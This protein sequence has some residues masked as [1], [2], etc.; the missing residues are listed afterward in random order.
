[1]ITLGILAHVDAGKT[2]LSEQILYNCKAIKSAGRV[3]NGDTLLDSDALEKQR[4]IT[5]YA[6][7]ACFSV[8]DSENRKKHFT[9]LDT[10][11][12]AD[13]SAEMERTLSVL[14]Y[15][16][17]VVSGPEGVQGHTHTLWKLFER[18][19]IPVFIFVNKM[20]RC[21]KSEDDII[22]DLHKLG[23]N[24][25]RPDD[26][27]NIAMCSDEL[28]E[29]YLASDLISE[30]SLKAAIANRKFTPVYFGSALKNE[31]VDEFTKAFAKLTIEKSNSDSDFSARVFKITHDEKH[32]R[33]THMKVLSG[34]LKIRDKIGEEKVNGIRIYNGGSFAEVQ[35]AKAGDLIT[36]PGLSDTY[37]GQ[38]IGTDDAPEPMITPVMTYKLIY[39]ADIS[40]QIMMQN[41]K[42]LEEENPEFAF[43]WD[44]K[45]R[46]IH[47]RVMGIIQLEILKSEIKSRYDVDVDFGAGSIVYKETV[48]EAVIGVG[49]F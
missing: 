12:H 49:H 19:E 16:V 27:E 38:G 33:L 18:Y 6:S 37:P 46:E 41:L 35:E 8:M 17:L 28:M 34:E 23:A 40:P 9:I 26:F 14:D 7:R 20:D 24:A 11:G 31:G 47:V 30:E 48:D 42:E 4:G 10:P 3:D 5:I 25:Y 15:A 13:F 32:N 44:E 29:E 45:L 36:I 39:P 2:T 21:E 43:E 1:M 22:E